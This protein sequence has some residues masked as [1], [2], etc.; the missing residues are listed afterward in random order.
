VSD[1][2]IY[3]RGNSLRQSSFEN[4][5]AEDVPFCLSNKRKVNSKSIVKS[6]SESILN[7]DR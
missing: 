1:E 2:L 3:V 6:F 5:V 7:S 4:G